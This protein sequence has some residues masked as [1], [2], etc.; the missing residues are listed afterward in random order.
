M[1]P[2][3]RSLFQTVFAERVFSVTSIRQWKTVQPDI[4][5]TTDGEAFKM[6][7]LKTHYFKLACNVMR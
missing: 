4:R 7:S 6:A 5:K 3:R 2:K 1:W